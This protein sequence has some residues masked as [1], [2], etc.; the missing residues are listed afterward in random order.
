MNPS[1]LPNRM[2]HMP[3]G[4][5]LLRAL[6]PHDQ[7]R[8]QDFFY[9]HDEDTI[10]HRY[11]HPLKVMGDD[12]ARRLVSVDQSRDLA[13]ALFEVFGQKQTIHGVGRYCMNPDGETAEVAFVVRESKRRLGIAACLMTEMIR[14]ARSRG[15]R[16]LWAT[17][18]PNNFPMI[19]ALKKF[20]FQETSRDQDEVRLSLK[21]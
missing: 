16:G 12:D 14:L 20:G 11:G 10:Y 17:V 3:D 4:E 8:L 13:L 19:K 6:G 21:F 7:Q 15:L 5:Y 1:D 9:S 2:M 18:M